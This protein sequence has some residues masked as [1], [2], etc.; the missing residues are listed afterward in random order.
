MAK[1]SKQKQKFQE[2]DP[3]HPVAF[4]L[5][6]HLANAIERAYQEKSEINTT[7][8]ALASLGRKGIGAVYVDALSGLQCMERAPEIAAYGYTLADKYVYSPLDTG[9]D[10]LLQRIDHDIEV[11]P[12][13]NAQAY[14]KG[15]ATANYQRY[16]VRRTN[17]DLPMPRQVGVHSFFRPDLLMK[18]KNQAVRLELALGALWSGAVEG[19]GEAHPFPA[20]RP[21]AI[22]HALR[23]S[24]AVNPD[25]SKALEA[26][27][28][29]DSDRHNESIETM[30]D[31]V[32]EAS[33]L[34]AA[35]EARERNASK[36]FGRKALRMA[37]WR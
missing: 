1:D 19:F 4:T 21:S 3:G 13:F 7:A 35:A 20:Y 10:A 5:E 27:R 28:Y 2:D 31:I 6:D 26:V 11:N 12:L 16:M 25:V 32:H 17:Y 37:G 18:P 30:L 8:E 14:H 36:T 23:S 15:K 33:K 24:G 29:E 9:G 22:I 34:I